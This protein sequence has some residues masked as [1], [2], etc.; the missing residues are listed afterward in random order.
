MD[1][2]INEYEQ[3]ANKYI[4]KN[5]GIYLIF[6]TGFINE[7]KHYYFVLNS[8]NNSVVKHIFINKKD[9]KINKKNIKELKN[10]K[11]NRRLISLI[12][13][14]F[15]YEVKNYQQNEIREDSFFC[16]LPSNNIFYTF[17][18]ESDDIINNGFYD[19]INYLL[20]YSGIS[21]YQYKR[22]EIKDESVLQLM[23]MLDDEITYNIE[24]NNKSKIQR[25]I[26]YEKYKRLYTKTCVDLCSMMNNYELIMCISVTD[27]VYLFASCINRIKPEIL[28]WEKLRTK[29]KDKFDNIINL[30]SNKEFIYN[31]NIT[32]EEKE[33]I[34]NNL[35]IDHQ[36][37]LIMGLMT[38]N[39]IMELSKKT[40]NWNAK[41]SIMKYI[42]KEE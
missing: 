27:Y 34:I 7:I 25:K 1:D 11:N 13:Y 33:N 26:N 3:I 24:K 38:N 42:H 29:K 10:V 36:I 19:F 5:D 21:N 35:E 40:N 32:N 16:F 22:K 14:T 39:E 28:D 20:V 6:S 41:L 2:I 30:I 12:N 18:N 23:I 15:N 37:D 4:N 9:N 31:L 8:D 17:N